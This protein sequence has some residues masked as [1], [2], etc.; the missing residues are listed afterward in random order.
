LEGQPV[1][2]TL[3]QLAQFVS[4]IVEQFER[5]NKIGEE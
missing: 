4:G 2:P 1:L 3:R 5:V